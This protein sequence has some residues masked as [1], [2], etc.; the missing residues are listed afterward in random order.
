[1]RR[2]HLVEP[3]GEG[4][5]YQHTA[6]LAAALLA[7][8]AEVT[9]YTAA[10][11][12]PLPVR[13]PRQACLWRFAW[14]KPRR[15]RQLAILLGWLLAGVPRCALRLRRGD[16]L[17]LQGWFSPA[18]FVPLVLAARMR[19]CFFAYS[20]HVTYARAGRRQ[21]RVVAALCRRADVT[22]A[23]S[24]HDRRTLS[25][26]GVRSTPAPFPALDAEPRADLVDSWRR[27]WLGEEEGRVVLF[28]GQVRR[29]K[30]LDVLVR[31]APHWRERA[32]L[33]VVGEDQGGVSDARAL[34]ERLGVRVV[35]DVG[36]QPFERFLAAVAA[37][38]LVACPYRVASQSGVLALA[39]SAGRPTVA[40]D[41]GGLAELA[42]VV[43]PPGDPRALAAAVVEGLEAEA[44]ARTVGPGDVGRF[45]LDAYPR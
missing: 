15:P 9:V 31:S 41:V 22:F 38:D 30:G 3:G 1:M 23:F 18:L 20:P 27:R 6:A 2:V 19:G 8:G 5:I 44:P 34:A 10:Y 45:Y 28:A 14:I 17:H 37:A 26:W 42:T 32:V 39:R 43:A 40:T 21:G 24:E 16:V 33:A 29:D 4:G 13:V 36:F 25:T 12:E 11:A 35:W 7:E